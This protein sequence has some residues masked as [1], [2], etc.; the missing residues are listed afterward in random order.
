MLWLLT[1]YC[2]HAGTGARPLDT[3]LAILS[4]TASNASALVT[5]AF[6]LGQQVAFRCITASDVSLQ[7]MTGWSIINGAGAY[8]T[9]YLLRARESNLAS[10]SL[11]QSLTLAV[12]SSKVLLSCFVCLHAQIYRMCKGVP[13]ISSQTD[14]WVS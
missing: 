4:E 2:W 3:A 10:A 8:G 11:L 5:T 6:Q 7:T 12:Q 9:D 14:T 13:V 1:A